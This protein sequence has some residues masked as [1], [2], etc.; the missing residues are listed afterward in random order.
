M[1][2]TGKGIPRLHSGCDF[3]ANSSTTSCTNTLKHDIMFL[4]KLDMMCSTNVFFTSKAL[5]YKVFSHLN[6]FQ[7]SLTHRNKV[8]HIILICTPKVRH[9][10]RCIF[11]CQKSRKSVRQNSN[12]R[13]E[14]IFLEEGAEGL[15]PSITLRKAY[16]GK[17]TT[18]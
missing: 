14:R 17:V 3:S 12:Q 8:G 7:N 18:A 13:W 10:L 6:V 4:A 9:F 15:L 2:K 16:P 5:F 1:N 11:L